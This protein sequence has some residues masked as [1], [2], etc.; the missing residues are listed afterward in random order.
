METKQISKHL[1]RLL[2]DPNNYRFIDS[3]DYKPVPESQAGDSRIQQRTLNLI[4]G[5]NQA[6][7]KDLIITN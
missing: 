3:K 1:D 2:L 5:K 4:M 7:N 6:S